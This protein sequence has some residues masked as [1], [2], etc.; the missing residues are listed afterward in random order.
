MNDDRDAT[1]GSAAGTA[2]PDASTQQLDLTAVGDR[3]VSCGAPLSNDQRYCV[4][5]GERR[6]RPRFA[7]TETAGSATEVTT[8]SRRPPRRPRAPAGGT[9]VAGVGTLVLA[10]GVGVLIGRTDTRAA[11]STAPPKTQIVYLGGSNPNRTGAAGTAATTTAKH[12]KSKS[13]SKSKSKSKSKPTAATTA[14]AG[15]AASKVLGGK[16]LPPATV[17]VGASGHGPGYQ[18]GHFNGSFFGGG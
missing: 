10:M 11:T 5:C 16:S 13:G 2:S 7:L 1:L 18:N 3:C 12:S 8:T 14:K 17:T 9:L 4:N 6:N 15:A